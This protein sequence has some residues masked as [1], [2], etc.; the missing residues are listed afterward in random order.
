MSARLA[1]M[2]RGG[3]GSEGV[4]LGK[5]PGLPLEL[6]EFEGCPFCRKVREAISLLELPTR[7]FPCPKGGTRHRPRALK[8]S[9]RASFPTLVDP[10]L[11]EGEQVHQESDRIVERLFAQ[12]GTTSAPPLLRAGALGDALSALSSGLRR[13]GS[14]ARASSVELPSNLTLY[15]H[16][17][18][19][20]AR[21]PKEVLCELELPYLWLPDPRG[22]TR[23][24]GPSPRLTDGDRSLE[25][26]KDIV[27][28]LEAR[29]GDPR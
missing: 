11:A 28:Y 20:A 26:G 16:E 3:L 10:N 21:A 17:G 27:A 5:R 8:L 12:Y 19:A 2:A 7:V 4:P 25:G 18:Q 23:D 9:A 13:R 14:R 1:V 22:G 6:Y 24:R 29:Y 15:A